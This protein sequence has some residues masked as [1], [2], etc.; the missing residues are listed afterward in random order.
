MATGTRAQ[1][2]E[3]QMALLMQMINEEQQQQQLIAQEQRAWREEL[4]KEHGAQEERQEKCEAR[5]QKWQEDFVQMQQQQ[6]QQVITEYCQLM[7]AQAKEHL[8]RHELL[9]QKVGQ[10]EQRQGQEGQEFS[11]RQRSSSSLLIRVS[12][13]V[14]W[15]LALDRTWVWQRKSYS[16]SSV[17]LLKL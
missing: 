1:K 13:S 3:E 12:K 15:S 17:S 5:L 6:H 8:S 11:K 4:V 9:F 10:L 2:Q 14:W 16:S 7:Q